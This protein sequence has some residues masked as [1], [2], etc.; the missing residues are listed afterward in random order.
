LSELPK[1]D[2]ARVRGEKCR[3]REKLVRT[4]CPDLFD[5]NSGT[6]MGTDG[7]LAPR[8]AH[9]ETLLKDGTVLVTEGVS[10]GGAVATAEL[11]Q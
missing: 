9:A 1:N 6:L 4:L 5:P 8:V 10:S 7:T 3:Q 2:E 11:Y